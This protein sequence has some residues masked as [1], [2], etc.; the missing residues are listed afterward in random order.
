MEAAVL[1]CTDVNGIRNVDLMAV[2]DAVCSVECKGSYGTAFFD[3]LAADGASLTGGQVTVIAVSQINAD[4]LRS[5][6]L[7]LLHSLLCLGNID[8]IVILAHIDSLLLSIS[9]KAKPPS[10]KKPT[11]LSARLVLPGMKT[12]HMFF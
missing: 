7:E 2:C 10:R 1:L 12:I 11:F 8:L 6:H 3:H 5:L 4:F 9:G